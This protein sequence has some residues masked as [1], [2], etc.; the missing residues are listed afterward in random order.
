MASKEKLNTL[1]EEVKSAVLEEVLAEVEKMFE[2]FANSDFSDL[3]SNLLGDKGDQGEVGLQGIQGIK[4]DLGPQGPK[5]DTGPKG[6]KGD[7]VVGAQGPKGEKGD[8]GVGSPDTGEQIVGKINALEAIEGKQIDASHIKNLISLIKKHSE[9]AIRLG[10]G[11]ITLETPTG[12]VNGVNTIFDVTM[13]PK[14]LIVDGM[15][16]FQDVHYTLAGSRITITDG[17]PP[18]TFIRA[19]V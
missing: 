2:E 7:F 4:G 5:G 14:Y 8:A 17:A 15:S 18:V 12:T 9:G 10:G 13:S 19:I 3:R 16:K 1:I 6:E 11:G